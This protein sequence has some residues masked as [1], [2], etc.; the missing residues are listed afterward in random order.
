MERYQKRIRNIN[1]A[2]YEKLGFTK[3]QKGYFDPS[4]RTSES[5]NEKYD[6]MIKKVEIRRQEELKCYIDLCWNN[7]ERMRG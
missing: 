3:N 6:D 5:I 2:Q 1:K 7:R 4:D